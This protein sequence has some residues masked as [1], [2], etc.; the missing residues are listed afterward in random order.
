MWT[1][2]GGSYQKL[3]HSPHLTQRS[4]GCSFWKQPNNQQ[5]YYIIDQLMWLH[6][7]WHPNRQ[8]LVLSTKG[9]RLPKLCKG[10]PSRMP[11]RS[12]GGT[13][14]LLTSVAAV[15]V[16]RTR[17]SAGIAEKGHI[18]VLSDKSRSYQM[19]ADGSND[20][21][22]PL[23]DAEPLQPILSGAAVSF[24]FSA[25]QEFRHVRRRGDDR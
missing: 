17:R 15:S 5:Q 25:Q 23:D 13:D 8:P 4:K 11:P 3:R 16:L 18:A 9:K 1:T 10:R 12:A 19:C 2:N 24:A 22:M 21:D 14:S 20:A 7:H 6:H